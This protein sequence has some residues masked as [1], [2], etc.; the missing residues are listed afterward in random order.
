MAKKTRKR[1]PPGKGP[2]PAIPGLNQEL[3]DAFSNAVFGLLEHNC[4]C[5]SA[6]FVRLMVKY[7]KD[8]FKGGEVVAQSNDLTPDRLTNLPDPG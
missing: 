6:K 4:S 7:R 8:M 5:P 1:I 2:G 3:A